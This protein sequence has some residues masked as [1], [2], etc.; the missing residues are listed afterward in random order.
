MDTFFIFS[1]TGTG[2]AAFLAM[3]V[4]PRGGAVV[5]ATTT[6]NRI[7]SVEVKSYFCEKLFFQTTHPFSTP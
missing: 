6:H 5:L 1:L 4:P 7:L 3:V 2:T